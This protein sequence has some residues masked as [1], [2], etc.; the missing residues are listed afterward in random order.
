M[1]QVDCFSEIKTKSN[2]L[3]LY[4]EDLISTQN[5]SWDKHFGFDVIFL[6]S[7]WIQKELALKEINELHQ[8][9]QIG[10][11]KIS[12]KYCYHW[13]VDGFRQSCINSL[14]SKDHYSYTLFGEYKDEFYHNNL[15]ELKYKPY[16]YYLFNNQKNH[17]ILNLDNKDRYLFSLYFEKETSYEILRD[18]LKSILIKI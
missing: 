17:T 7:S 3:A 16:T 8:I 10:L 5:L 11:L 2:K 4:L 13:H 18:K 14:I 12:G 1:N 15:I 9:K 6:D